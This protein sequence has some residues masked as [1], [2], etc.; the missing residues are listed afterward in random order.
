MMRE[1][2]DGLL[3]LLAPPA[4]AACNSALEAREDGF[5]TGCAL[6]IEEHP[7]EDDAEDRSACL[8]GGPISEAIAQLKY[9][10]L[11][12]HARTLAGLLTEAA[13]PWS[14]RIDRVCV[15]P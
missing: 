4:C 9:R 12:H 5:C 8:Y 2:W 1:L 6:L 7:N 3:E 13:E 11:S 15:V 14:G 10:G